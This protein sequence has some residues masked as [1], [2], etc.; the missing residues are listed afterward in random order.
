MS[1]Q[2]AMSAMCMACGSGDV[3]SVLHRLGEVTVTFTACHV[4][5]AKWWER[6]GAEIP[7][8]TV[9]RLVPGV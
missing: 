5:S 7:L 3:I 9:L 2:P 1:A 8:E 4:C 6:D